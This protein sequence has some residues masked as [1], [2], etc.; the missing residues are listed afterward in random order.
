MGMDVCGRKPSSPEGEYFRA[1][2]W[3]WRPIH[4]LIWELCSDLLDKETLERMAFNDGAGPEDQ[5]TCIVMA[6]R[7]DRWLERH[8]EGK[9][10][11]SDVQTTKEGRFVSKEELEENPDLETETPYQVEDDHLKE[12]VAFLRHCGG[13]EVW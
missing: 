6:S 11:E 4:S 13:F 8:V 9:Q 3:S 12:W 7:F 5:T 10:L 1:N 2:V